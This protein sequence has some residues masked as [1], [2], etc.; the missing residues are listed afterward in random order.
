MF[1]AAEIGKKLDKKSYAEK[2]PEVRE[3]LLDVQFRLREADFSVVVVVAGAEGAGKGEVVN[4]LLEWLDARGIETHAMS[5]PTEEES[6]RPPYYRFWRRLPPR[7]KIAIFFG[8]WYTDPIVQRIDGLTDEYRFEREMHHIVEFE[9]MLTSERTLLV[10]VWLHIT[11]RQQKRNLKRLEN[12]PETAW[13][14]TKQD[15]DYHK[16]YD[17]FIKVSASAICLTSTGHAPW[18]IVESSD[19]RHRD[20]D[21]AEHLITCIGGRLNAAT[22]SQPTAGPLPVPA[23]HNVINSLDLDQPLEGKDYESDLLNWKEQLGKLARR[24]TAQSLSAVL[25]FEGSDGAGKGGCVRRV[26]QTLDARYYQVIPVAAPSDEELARPY[27]WRFWRRLPRAGHIHIYDRSWYGRVLVE[28]IEGFCCPTDWRRAYAEIN[29]FEQEL[30]ENRTLVIKFWLAISA[31]EQLKRFKHR[32]ETKHKQH[33]LTAEDWRNR[34]KAPA[35][36]AAACD[37]IAQTS[38]SFAP[39]TLVEAN[40]KR[41]ARVKVLRTIC[42]RLEEAT[43]R[44][45]KPKKRDGK[46]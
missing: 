27:L 45:P 5:K 34:E 9:R 42:Q 28:R 2:L 21:V 26:T 11:K 3:K 12:K 29:A 44:L 8:S 16:T 37:M 7:G 46:K 33:K 6:E 24:M 32:E 14:V 10:K 36:E 1:E 23:K 15:W 22:P 39:W 30:S 31:D 43:D 38:T 25:V 41:F 13:R 19:R 4:R 35:Y 17:E 18:H 20:I 40:N